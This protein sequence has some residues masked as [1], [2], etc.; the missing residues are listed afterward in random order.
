[1]FGKGKGPFGSKFGHNQSPH[2]AMTRA[3]WTPDKRMGGFDVKLR[4]HMIERHEK[5]LRTQPPGTGSRGRF[6]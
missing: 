4:E 1:M 3:L 6:R 2:A 5:H